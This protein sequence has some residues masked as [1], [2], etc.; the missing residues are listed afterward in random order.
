[1]RT[2]LVKINS[3]KSKSKQWRWRCQRH[4]KSDFSKMILFLFWFSKCP[5]NTSGVA[6]SWRLWGINYGLASPARGYVLLS[7]G[8]AEDLW[9]HFSSPRPIAGGSVDPAHQQPCAF[10]DSWLL[11]ILTDRPPEVQQIDWQQLLNWFNPSTLGLPPSQ[12]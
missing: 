6:K 5:H 1:M 10:S 7:S 9:I 8:E 4:L 3:S 2:W 11:Y 12:S